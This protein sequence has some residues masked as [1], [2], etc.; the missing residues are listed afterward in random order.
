MLFRRQPPFGEGQVKKPNQTVREKETAMYRSVLVPLDG[1]PFGEHALPLA[2]SVARRAKARLQLVHV[3][4]PLSVAYAEAML[5]SDP[6]LELALEARQRTYLTRM[7]EQVKRVAAVDVSFTLLLGETASALRAHAVKEKADLIVMTT[8]GR[9]ALGRFWL[10]S[11]ADELVR[12]LPMPILLVRP[13][14]GEPTWQQEP[15]LEHLLLPLDGTPLAE[16]ILEPAI[17]LGTLMGADYT[18]LRAIKP[19]L[20]VGY[21]QAGA[22]LGESAQ[23][24]M[25]QIEATHQRL[26]REAAAYLNQVAERLRQQK[27]EVRTHVIVEEQPGRAIIETAEAGDIDSIALETHGRRGL[28]R[29]MLGSVADKVIRG[30]TV[31]VLVQRPPQA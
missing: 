5:V 8:H 10:G 26:C 13:H 30:A 19:V 1:S 9:G 28:S 11:V 12:H 14:E 6:D 29:L 16:Q 17:A 7:V 18:L 24:L 27:L 2:I 25:E 20:A 4:T 15:V 21:P 31:P 3:A 23:K 22:T